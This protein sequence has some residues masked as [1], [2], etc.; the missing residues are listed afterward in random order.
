MIAQMYTARIG[1]YDTNS[2]SLF[3]YYDGLIRQSGF[4]VLGYVEH[5]F[6]GDGIKYPDGWTGAWILSESH[7]AIHTFAEEYCSYVELSSCVE[8]HYKKFIETIMAEIAAGESK[9]FDIQESYWKK[10]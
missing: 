6:P 10:K 5:H 3:K 4:G 8:I 9:V 2:D 7:L 1:T